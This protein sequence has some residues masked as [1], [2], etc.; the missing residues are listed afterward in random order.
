MASTTTTTTGPSRRYGSGKYGVGIAELAFDTSALASLIPGGQQ[1]NSASLSLTIQN[2]GNVNGLA[3]QIE[4]FDWSPTIDA[5]DYTEVPAATA[6]NAPL[7]DLVANSVNTLPL[8]SPTSININGLTYF[9]MHISQRVGDAA[10]TGLN[11]VNFYTYDQGGSGGLLAPYLTVIYGPP[12][13]TP[14]VTPT[15][16]ATATPTNTPGATNTPTSTPTNTASP[17]G[18]RATATPTQ[19]PTNTPSPTVTQTPTIT[20]TPGSTDCCDCGVPACV[21][22]TGGTC[23]GGCAVTHNACCGC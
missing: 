20:P 2:T 7:A 14:T 12:P 19:T 6:L 5:S 22:P 15:P 17:T 1:I 16:A 13:A 3:L 11:Y 4:Y 10:P 8:L 21:N 18:T 9:R 23:P